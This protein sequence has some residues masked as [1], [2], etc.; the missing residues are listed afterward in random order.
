MAVGT[1]GGPGDAVRELE[2]LCQCGFTPREA[3]RIGT[4]DTARALGMEEQIGTLV[5]GKQADLVLVKK[6]V[7][8]DITVFL[9]PENI[10]L[11]FTAG[12]RMVVSKA[13]KRYYRPDESA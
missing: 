3:L 8:E 7:L 11:T 9:D 1:D 4:G 10:L 12:R 5:P 13:G 2:E 6:E